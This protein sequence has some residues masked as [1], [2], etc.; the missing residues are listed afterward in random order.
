MTRASRAESGRGRTSCDPSRGKWQD[1]F[2]QP[3]YPDVQRL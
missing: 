1:V 3:D 2:R